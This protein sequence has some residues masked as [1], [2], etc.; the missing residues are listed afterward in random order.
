[1]RG[2]LIVRIGD[3]PSGQQRDEIL[4][5]YGLSLQRVGTPEGLYLLRVPE[6]QERALAAV[7]KQL[8]NVVYAQPNYVLSI[9]Q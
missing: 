7:L 3:S 2:Q 9:A 5:E 4:A 6:G 1:M 8:T